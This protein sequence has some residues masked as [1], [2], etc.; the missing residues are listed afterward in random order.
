MWT[1]AFIKVLMLVS[2]MQEIGVIWIQIDFGLLDTITTIELLNWCY[3]EGSMPTRRLVD[4]DQVGRCRPG[5]VDADQ[6]GG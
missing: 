3:Q 5:R 6:K 1:L 2:L 4:A